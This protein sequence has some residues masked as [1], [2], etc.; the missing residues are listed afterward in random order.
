MSRLV[1]LCLRLT[2]SECLRSLAFVR[3][4]DLPLP[5]RSTESESPSLACFLPVSLFVPLCVLYSLWVPL[6]CLFSF[7][8]LTY[9]PFC[10][11]QRVSAPCTLALFLYPD[12]SLYRC[13]T[14]SEYPLITAFF[15]L[16]FLYDLPLCL[17]VGECPLLSFFQ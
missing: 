4:L 9:L 1:R 3:L 12:L 8:G 6:A 10:T 7:G 2:G 17:T 5:L 13:S 11:L 16:V 15:L 14:E